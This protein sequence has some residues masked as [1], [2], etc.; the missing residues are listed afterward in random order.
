M[1]KKRKKQKSWK[2]KYFEIES[3]FNEWL[4]GIAL[5]AFLIGTIFGSAMMGIAIG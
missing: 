5:L 3:K 4:F 1:Q 2:D